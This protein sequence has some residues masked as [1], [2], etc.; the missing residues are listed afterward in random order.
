MEWVRTVA[1]L[2]RQ[3][4]LRW[5]GRGNAHVWILSGTIAL[6]GLGAAAVNAAPARHATPKVMTSTSSGQQNTT[7]STSDPLGDGD[8]C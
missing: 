6:A 8:G 5:L 2:L 1:G 3:R 7:P 4:A